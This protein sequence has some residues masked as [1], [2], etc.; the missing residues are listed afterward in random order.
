M[1]LRA[2]LLL[3]LAVWLAGAL[4]FPLH[5]MIHFLLVVGLIMVIVDRAGRD[6]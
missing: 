4:F 2:A 6:G 1:T 3:V 5:G